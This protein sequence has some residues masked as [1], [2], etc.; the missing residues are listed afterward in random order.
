MTELPSSRPPARAPV[1][2]LC[3][4]GCC[5]SVIF[6]SAR[7]AQP[8]DV[9]RIGGDAAMLTVDCPYEFTSEAVEFTP[10]PVT[11]T[12]QSGLSPDRGCR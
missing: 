3:G 12:A 10:P 8:V 6:L 1:R 4:M 9:G 5:G 2:S 11:L 7:L